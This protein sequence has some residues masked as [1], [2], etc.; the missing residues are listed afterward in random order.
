VTVNTSNAVLYADNTFAST[1]QPIVNA[2]INT[3]I[4]VAKDAYGRGATNTVSLRIPVHDN[5]S[6]DLN[7]SLLSEQSVGGTNRIFSYDDENELTSVLV[8]NLWRSDFAYDGK[9]RRRI[10]KDFTWSGGAWLQTNEVHYIYDG[11]VVIQERDTNNNV[12]VTYTRAGSAL[13]ARTDASHTAFYHMDG[14]AN[15]TCLIYTNQII[16]AKYLYDP[17]GNTLSQS[18]PLA[19]ANKYRFAS[20]EWNANAGLYYYGRRFYDPMLQRWLNRDPI[21]E[22]GGLNLY[23]Y[24]ANSPIVNLDAYGLA[25]MFPSDNYL[26]GSGCPPVKSIEQL[27]A[28][29]DELNGLTPHYFSDTG[30]YTIDG[31]TYSVDAYGNIN[32]S[33]ENN[34]TLAWALLALG[35]IP[36][37]GED[38]ALA[39]ELFGAEDVVAADTALPQFIYRTGSQTENALTDAAGVSFRDSISS[40]AT[41]AQVFQP[42]AKI[43][44]VDTS[45]LPSGSVIFDGNPAGHVSVF[46][47][48]AE[49]QSAIVPQGAANPLSD[50]SLKSLEDSSSYR[51]PK[52]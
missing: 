41:G 7:G 16:A 5:C 51:I 28:E 8:T 13:L 50:F 11:N 46:A 49:I 35:V 36:T 32:D 1:N 3:F 38:L 47:S 52:N 25:I 14:N 29:M 18:G 30:T 33:S 24:V 2:N 21:Q 39:P 44:T 37:G 23:G 20:K 22:L 19:D 34:N 6:Y 45:Q 17:F 42:G 15:V 4:A 31:V 9:F 26:S 43:Y 27:M 40:D 48:P 10:E 12:A